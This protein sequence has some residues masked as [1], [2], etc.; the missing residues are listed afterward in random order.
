[1]KNGLFPRRRTRKTLHSPHHYKLYQYWSSTLINVKKKCIR[2]CTISL[3]AS[4]LFNSSALKVAM[5]LFGEDANIYLGHHSHPDCEPTSTSECEKQK[6]RQHSMLFLSRKKFS[7]TLFTYGFISFCAGIARCFL[8]LRFSFFL[9]LN[10][11][12]VH[13]VD[14][15][16]IS[17]E[18]KQ[19]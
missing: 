14:V 7:L 17:T 12:E 9:H 6:I 4:L 3:V 13:R 8:F 1:M 16:G 15:L 2:M 19:G 11:R 10:N 5:Q 18:K